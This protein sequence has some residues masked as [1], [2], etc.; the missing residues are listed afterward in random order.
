MNRFLITVAVVVLPLFSLLANESNATIEEQ[1]ELIDL[2]S[3]SICKAPSASIENPTLIS[4]FSGLLSTE[5]WPARWTCGD[6]SSVEGWMY[7]SADLS[8]FL[9][10]LSIPIILLWYIRNRDI[11]KGRK[12]VTLFAAFILLCGFTH[13]IDVVLFWEPVYRLSGFL[14]LLT[15]VVSLG[16]ATVL[17][18]VIP[19]ALEYKSPQELQ[20]EIDERKKLQGQ[21]ETFVKYSPGATAMLDSEMR[22]VLANDG[23]HK[24]YGIE[25][26]AIIGKTML[27]V[28]PELKGSEWLERF[29]QVLKGKHL[30]KELD[31]YESNGRTEYFRWKLEPWYAEDS[32]IGGFIIFTEI[33]TKEVNQEEKLRESERR[34]TN[35]FNEAQFAIALVGDGGVP[36]LVNNQFVRLLG[37]TEEELTR[38]SF[39]EFTHPD[40]VK[41]DK[42]KYLALI[43]NKIDSYTIDKRYITKSGEIKYVKLN[44]TMVD[45]GTDNKYAMALVEDLTEAEVA[46]IMNA[47][48]DRM[49]AEVSA[50]ANIGSWEVDVKASKCFW[51]DTVYR[52]HEED[53]NKEIALEAGINYFHPDHRDIISK[54]VEEGITNQKPWDLELKIVTAKGNEKWTRA[55]GR[56]VYENG[57]VSKLQGL[58]QDIDKKKRYELEIEQSNKGLEEEVNDRTIALEKANEELEAFSYSV[59][60]DLRA[61]LRAINGY[62]E[63]LMED[64][65]S[66]I[67]DDANQYLSRITAN[68]QKMGAL[69]DDLLEFSRMN[70]K[71]VNYK[72]V[73]LNQLVNRIVDDLYA[74]SRKN[75]TINELPEITGDKEMLAQVFSNLISN[76]I[77]YSSKE[78]KPE[79]CISFVEEATSYVLSIQ[80]NGVGFNMEYYDK[81]FK[82]FQRLHSE[83]EFEGTGV[84][85]SLCAKIM[86]AHNGEIWA[87]SIKGEGATFYLRF[88][89]HN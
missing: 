41:K 16:T 42:D 82:V 11:G 22:F 29:N 76:A 36:F 65:A 27:E 5:N 39:E 70:R 86:K 7:I 73:D 83:S 77:K 51:S 30:S 84:G 69:I 14:K 88:K 54:A 62:S 25:G 37:Y 79:I 68:S 2:S 21:F 1:A 81:L 40:D 10:Y 24:A 78:E 87:D 18:F 72:S 74:E 58:F 9:A 31:S 35:I 60:H 50:V 52:I 67:P 85:L 17:G 28:F 34:F 6:W 49:M 43:A 71:K 63:A 61:P 20:A 45:E 32:N 15:G 66:K 38:M 23:Y 46:K 64:F 57:E 4:Y 80:D 59:S 47:D 8:I 33:L 56:A 55:I 12:L 75:I 89:K 19:K 44:V 48:M 53:P 3:V 26:V 13:L